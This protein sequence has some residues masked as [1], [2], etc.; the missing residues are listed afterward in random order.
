MS[1]VYIKELDKYIPFS[2]IEVNTVVNPDLM[3]VGTLRKI[4]GIPKWV[5]AAIMKSGNGIVVCAIGEDT[6]RFYTAPGVLIEV[7][8]KAAKDEPR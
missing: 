7:D 2:H 8:A 6:A 4:L 5:N 1:S 3:P